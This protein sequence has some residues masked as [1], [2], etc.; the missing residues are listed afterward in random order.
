MLWNAMI[1]F[2][3]VKKGQKSSNEEMS[4]KQR[5]SEIQQ[6]EA[7]Q[8]LV[9]PQEL[10]SKSDSLIEKDEAIQKL[11]NGTKRIEKWI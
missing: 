9:E 8:H 1:V 5:E 2:Y 3:T 7:K 11:G 4:L 10:N 6:Q